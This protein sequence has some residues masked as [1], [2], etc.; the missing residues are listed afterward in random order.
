MPNFGCRNGVEV[1]IGHCRCNCRLLGLVLDPQPDHGLGLIGRVGGLLNQHQGS[2]RCLHGI[3]L[4][5]FGSCCIHKGRS[6]LEC[7]IS[8]GPGSRGISLGS[9]AGI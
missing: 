2:L 4:G 5:A 6:L 3:G 1:G 7:H 9:L 8:L